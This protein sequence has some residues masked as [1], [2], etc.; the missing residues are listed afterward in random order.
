[1]QSGL[2]MTKDLI[3]VG[4]IFTFL[5]LIGIISNLHTQLQNS[6]SETLQAQHLVLRTQHDLIQLYSD[7][8]DLQESNASLH[9]SVQSLN[10]E[11]DKHEKAKATIDKIVK[12]IDR[13]Q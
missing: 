2:I 12:D 7:Y 8:A 6:K 5:M 1:M 4:V 13:V 10:A 9:Q 11:L 3:P